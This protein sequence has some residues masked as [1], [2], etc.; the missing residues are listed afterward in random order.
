MNDNR[1]KHRF[2]AKKRRI[3]DVSGGKLQD[4]TASEEQVLHSISTGAP[5]PVVLNEIC[6]GLDYPLGGM[7]SLISL[8]EDASTRTSE[9]A[10]NAT[11]FGLSPFYSATILSDQDE[12]LGFLD[13]YSGSPRKPSPVEMQLIERAIWL[14]AIAIQLDM[15]V[16]LG[17]LQPRHEEWSS[18]ENS[19]K[20]PVS[21]H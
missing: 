13:M 15:E 9:I 8:F 3:Q 2:P 12:P 18:Q 4:L 14:A 1:V 20:V 16:D 6:V 5:L 10:G 11:Q 17:S 7:V 21:I 19:S